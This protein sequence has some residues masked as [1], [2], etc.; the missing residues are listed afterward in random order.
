MNFKGGAP[1]H[2]QL[3]SLKGGANAYPHIVVRCC[4]E[5]TMHAPFLSMLA[6]FLSRSLSMS[7]SF[8]V[9]L[10]PIRIPDARKR[11]AGCGCR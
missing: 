6:L 7:L 3:N 11:R 5:L 8:S 10:S 4:A 9:S 1:A 2:Q